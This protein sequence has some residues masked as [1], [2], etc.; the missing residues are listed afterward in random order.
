[1]EVEIRPEPDD[2]AV[3][4]AAVRALLSSDGTPAAYRSS[5]RASGIRENVED[6]AEQGDAVG[7]GKSTAASRADIN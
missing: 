1:V 5:W 2:P 3:V 4:V 6:E 7:P